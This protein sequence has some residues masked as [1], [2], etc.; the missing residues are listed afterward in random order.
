MSKPIP[1]PP[2]YCSDWRRFVWRSID[3]GGTWSGGAA[4]VRQYAGRILA[5]QAAMS[6]RSDGTLL[7]TASSI[8][9]YGGGADTGTWLIEIAPD[10]ASADF[11]H[12]IF[13]T[14]ETLLHCRGGYGSHVI[15][16]NA[17]SMWLYEHDG[18]NLPPASVAPPFAL[19]ESPQSI[20]LNDSGTV[21]MAIDGGN[22]SRLYISQDGGTTWQFLV[23]IAGAQL[24]AVRH[25]KGT[26]W[27][28]AGDGVAYTP[29]DGITWRS[30]TGNFTGLIKQIHPVLKR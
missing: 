3:G 4:V 18:N 21:A 24:W 28:V 15:M 20:A 14:Q 8:D 5:D 16:W 22:Q 9:N 2:C 6:I 7:L 29:D 25:V 19:L 26:G 13:S 10:A 12:Q 11:L 30:K 23:E 1:S 17:G 27:I